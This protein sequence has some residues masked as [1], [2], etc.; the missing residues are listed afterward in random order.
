[1]MNNI[2]ALLLIALFSGLTLWAAVLLKGVC[3]DLY[4]TRKMS[5]ETQTRKHLKHLFAE[6][7][8]ATF[9][10]VTVTSIVMGAAL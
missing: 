6:Y 9:C 2:V 7:A 3:M 1:M 4:V 5:P 10:G 8:F